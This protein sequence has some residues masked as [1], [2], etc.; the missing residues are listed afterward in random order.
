MREGVVN[1]YTQRV[2][3]QFYL[4]TYTKLE[5]IDMHRVKSVKR[6]THTHTR[7]CYS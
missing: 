4:L 1:S 5:K 6:H 2:I 7:V 3:Y